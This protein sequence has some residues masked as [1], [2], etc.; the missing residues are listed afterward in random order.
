[1]PAKYL[2]PKDPAETRTER[3]DFTLD[4]G[5]ETISTFDAVTATVVRGADPTPAA[6]LN[7]AATQTGAYVYQSVIGGVADADYKL[8][9]RVTTNTGRKLVLVGILPVRTA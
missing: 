5:G 4:L 6:L 1:M 2:R 3:F 7:G 9:S 8:R